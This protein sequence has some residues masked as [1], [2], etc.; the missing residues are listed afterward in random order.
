ME[1]SRSL[2]LKGTAARLNIYVKQNLLIIS[3]NRD[4]PLYWK[5]QAEQNSY[6]ASTYLQKRRNLS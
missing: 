5:Q 1:E 6:T 2:L 4:H 3:V